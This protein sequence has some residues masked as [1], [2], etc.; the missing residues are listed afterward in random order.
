MRHAKQEEERFKHKVKMKPIED[1]KNVVSG[2][3]IST[4]VI[5]LFILTL[6]YLICQACDTIQLQDNQIDS[7]HS[8]KLSRP[9]P[10]F[11]QSNQEKIIVASRWQNEVFLPCR[12]NNL[13]EDQTVS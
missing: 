8:F 3:K 9:R 12:I 10:E 4:P 11:D 7:D 13:D 2:R 6:N 5:T 1:R